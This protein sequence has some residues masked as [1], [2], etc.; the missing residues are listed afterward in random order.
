ME[1][2]VYACFGLNIR[3]Q[4]LLPEI[5]DTPEP[6]E[7]LPCVAVR[8]AGAAEQGK[9]AETPHFGVSDFGVSFSVPNVAQYRV[10]N[11]NEI[12]VSPA[13]GAS[14]RNV[15]LYLLG[16]AF[17]LLCHQR[18]LMPLHANAIVVD[19]EAVAFAGTS[20]AGKSTLAAYFQSRGHQLLC[21]D[22]CVV[23]FDSDGQP[24]AWP[25]LS[26]LKLKADAVTAFGHDSEQLERV[27]ERWDKFHLPFSR[28]IGH[29]PLPL[30]RLYILRT[31]ETEAEARFFRLRG[32][33]AVE[34][35][36]AQTY[37][38]QFLGRMGLWPKHLQ[39]SV[40]LAER[41]EVYVAARTWGFDIF[42]READRLLHHAEI[43]RGGRHTF[44]DEAISG[45]SG[46]AIGD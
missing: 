22:V 27:V 11:G 9:G 39:R 3:S 1:D 38:S 20:G 10:A 34:A 32:A 16:S 12:V 46:E 35:V 6:D 29:G 44:V 18:G 4:I 31:H 37:R 41:S 30:R 23:S 28:D 25:G 21:D 24:L 42:G 40:A 45:H 2:H 14:M 26:R 15:R 17:G 36:A 13:P 7:R 43:P 19:G 5:Q 8:L 33:N